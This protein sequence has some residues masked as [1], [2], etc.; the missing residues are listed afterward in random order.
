MKRMRQIDG[1]DG[2]WG[3]K[4]EEEKRERRKEG[5]TGDTEAVSFVIR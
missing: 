5:K 2:C 4:S 1:E 3:G